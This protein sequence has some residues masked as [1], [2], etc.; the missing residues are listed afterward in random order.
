MQFRLRD[1]LVLTFVVAVILAF[2][3]PSIRVSREAAR[4]T[5]CSNNLKQ[6]CLGI[7]NYHDTFK[8]I[9]PASTGFFAAPRIGWQVRMIPFTEQTAIYESLNMK[10]AYLPWEKTAINRGGKGGPPNIKTYQHASEIQVPY[11]MCP[12]DPR[13]SVW[14]GWAQSSYSGNLGSQNVASGSRNC[15]PFHVAG[16]H[17]QADTGEVLF[18]DT[19]DP[20]KVS[21]IFSRQLFGPVTFDDVFD[22]TSN[23]FA[24]GEILAD[25][26]PN[27]TG[28]WDSDGAGNAHA[29]TTVPLNLMTTCAQSQR[30]AGNYFMPACFDK[31]NTNFSWGFRSQHPRGANFAM[32]DGSV[33]FISG[34]INYHIYQR[35][36]SRADSR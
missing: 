5:Q 2:L 18:G 20:A 8:V 29:S 11:A 13:V 15:Q 9:P 32:C 30:G 22:G 21:G 28:W 1:L 19:D 34:D 3:L 25:C 24:V 7:H 23:T 35:Y 26:H 36:G 17:Y 14:Q 6:L 4:R 16:V 31:R 33:Q 27:Q 10:L 12:D